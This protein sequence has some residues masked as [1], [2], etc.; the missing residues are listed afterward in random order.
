MGILVA[1]VLLTR[2]FGLGLGNPH[3]VFVL[4][5]TLLFFFYLNSKWLLNLWICDHFNWN[6]FVHFVRMFKLYV[7]ISI[8]LIQLEYM[9]VKMLTDVTLF[10]MAPPTHQNP[11]PPPPPPPPEAW[12]A[13]MAATNANTQMI[14]QLLQERNQGNQ[15]NGNNQTQFA[16]L[17]QFLQTSRSLLVTVPSPQTLTIGSWISANI[18][19]VATSGLRT[20][21]S[22]L[23][24]N[25]KTKLQNG[26][27]STKIPEEVV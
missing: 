1:L 17:N 6:A 10:R 4:V 15:G 11:E 2:I 8:H 5:R 20:L 25:S 26:F 13:V 22:S 23:P 24:S 19:S 9:S 18:L 16:T 3:Q 21:S 27:S 14:M 7:A 12:Q